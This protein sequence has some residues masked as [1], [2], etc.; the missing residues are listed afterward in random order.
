MAFF[1]EQQG[2]YQI[3]DD[4]ARLQLDLI[5]AWLSTQSYWAVGRP[6]ETVVRSIQNSLCLG[7]Y[8]HGVQVGFA[9]M[10]TDRA[11]FA[12]LC[13]V[14]IMQEERGKGLAKWLVGCVI[15]HPDLQGLRRV[16]LATRDAHSLYQDYGG[17]APLKA[18][19]R[20]MER[21]NPTPAAQP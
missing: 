1:E 2:E 6:Y 21:F 9:R 16:L 11:T 7:V 17:F 18:P 3:S 8:H 5:H 10:V 20:F 13:D 15:N 4:P 14:F 19:E 12:W